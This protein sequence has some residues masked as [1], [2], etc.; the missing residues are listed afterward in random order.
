[1]AAFGCRCR[2]ETPE[3]RPQT[4]DSR[5]RWKKGQAKKEVY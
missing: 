3:P 5:P 4:P 1:L 2:P